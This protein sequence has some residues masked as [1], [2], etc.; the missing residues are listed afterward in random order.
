M[1]N[2]N[3]VV[4]IEPTT[5]PGE[6]DTLLEKKGHYSWGRPGVPIV[7]RKGFHMK[8]GDGSIAMEFASRFVDAKVGESV[9]LEMG[10]KNR[11]LTVVVNKQTKSFV[12]NVDR[13][14]RGD[15]PDRREIVIWWALAII[16]CGIYVALVNKS[17]LAKSYNVLQSR[18][19]KFPG[20]ARE[21]QVVAC[22]LD[23]VAESATPICRSQD[24]PAMFADILN[25]YYAR[26]RNEGDFTHIEEARASVAIVANVLGGYGCADAFLQR[27]VLDIQ[28]RKDETSGKYLPV[29]RVVPAPVVPA[30]LPPVPECAA[31]S[32]LPDV[33]ELEDMPE[34]P[35]IFMPNG[36]RLRRDVPGNA[37]FILPQRQGEGGA[38]SAWR[39]EENARRRAADAPTPPASEEQ[40]DADAPSPEDDAL[41]NLAN[42]D[43]MKRIQEEMLGVV[44]KAQFDG[45]KPATDGDPSVFRTP[46]T[47]K[48]T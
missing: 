21:M 14:V 7:F 23:M 41:I 38:V 20:M 11:K 42:E 22:L 34:R 27:V 35:G 2:D 6:F 45:P 40:H 3:W 48:G 32:E 33:R 25:T 5:A 10:A 30:E 17:T 15:K 26:V 1:F 28:P 36:R 18:I 29:E 9:H 24:L 37:R 39:R 44:A 47:K 12:A 13:L 19:E 16:T 43:P 31:T 46:P 8:G 4:G